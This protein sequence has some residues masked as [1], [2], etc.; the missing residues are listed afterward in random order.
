MILRT[1]P[2]GPIEVRRASETDLTEW[3]RLRALL[4]PSCPSTEH[5][6]EVAEYLEKGKRVA[7]VAAGPS[8]RRSGFLEATIRPFAEGCDTEPVGYIEGWYVD[9]AARR[10]GVGRRLVEAAEDWA[11]EHGCVEIG[12]DCLIKNP[13]SL[14]AHRA[15]GYED[16][17]RLIHFRKGLTPRRHR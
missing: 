6:K 2:S 8:Q 5:R 9:A 16:R 15:I 14:R 3:L 4:W 11:R 17:E 13:V 7:F 12:S 10:R 1:D